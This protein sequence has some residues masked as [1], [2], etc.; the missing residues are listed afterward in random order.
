M[1]IGTFY[2]QFPDK[3]DLMRY[4]MDEEHQYRVRGFDAL[5]AA[6]ADDFSDRVAGILAGSEPRLLVAM[7]EAIG[8]D[9]RLRDFA[10]DLREG[11]RERLALAVTSARKSR[12]VDQAFLDPSTAAWAALLMGDVSIQD[13][14]SPNVS[15][16]IDVLA[17]G[18]TDR[19]AGG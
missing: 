11:T 7:V 2:H 19:I 18:R 8:A 5:A 13:P 12:H 10:R 14:G 16:A 15:R 9:E 6:P 3:S 1:G 4:L 17:F